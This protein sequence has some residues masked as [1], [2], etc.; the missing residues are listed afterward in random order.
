MSVVVGPMFWV[1]GAL[2]GIIV[3]SETTDSQ[4]LIWSVAILFGF[5]GGL[6]HWYSPIPNHNGG[7]G[8]PPAKL[9]KWGF[10]SEPMYDDYEEPTTADVMAPAVPTG[11]SFA[12]RKREN[13]D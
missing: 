4:L 6:I 1:I 10:T 3:A 12:K 8:M 9:Q 5:L 11:W 13:G 2:I 7:F